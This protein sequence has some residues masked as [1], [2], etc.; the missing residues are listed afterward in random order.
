MSVTIQSLGLDKLPQEDR[1][2][3][4]QDLIQSVAP[5]DE[6]TAEQWAEIEIRLAQ[7]QADPTSALD[8]QMLM[9][10]LRGEIQARHQ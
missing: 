5:D 1:L 6:L 9:A 8:G 2:R 10:A 3:L 7:H 4:A